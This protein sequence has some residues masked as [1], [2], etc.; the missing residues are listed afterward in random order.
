[1]HGEKARWELNKNT[2][3]CFKQILEATPHQTAAV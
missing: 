3:C 1:M 2:M